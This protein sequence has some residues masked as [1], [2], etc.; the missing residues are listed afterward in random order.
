MV[1]G[2]SYTGLDE[3]LDKAYPGHRT[4]GDTTLHFG[5]LAAIVLASETAKDFHFVSVPPGTIL[6][7]P[8]NT[9]IK[10]SEE[11]AMATK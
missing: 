5:P 4:N 8:L 11:A 1:N 10:V 3:V 9:K 2:A 6:L 7:T